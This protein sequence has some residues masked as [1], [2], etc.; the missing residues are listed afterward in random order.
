MDDLVIIILTLI[1]AAAGI[2]GQFK[3][4]KA[5]EPEGLSNEADSPD[6][7]WEF[8]EKESDQ[9][10]QP[11]YETAKV[12]EDISKPEKQPGMSTGSVSSKTGK[13]SFD[14]NDLTREQMQNDLYQTTKRKKFPLRK[15][16]I[17][18]EI[19]NRKYI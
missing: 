4:K 17:Y 16:V 1:F 14:E 8:L 19:L 15:A 13:A 6:N 5:E 3:K 9:K 11:K 10:E 2:L 18:S 12:E 7:F